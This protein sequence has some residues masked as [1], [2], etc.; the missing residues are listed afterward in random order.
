MSST[1]VASPSTPHRDDSREARPVLATVPLV[2]ALVA[3]L[4]GGLATGAFTELV[5]GL[6]DAGPRARGG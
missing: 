6:G 1:Q 5:T 4:A 2:G 3:L